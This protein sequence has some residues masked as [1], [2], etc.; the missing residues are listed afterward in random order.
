ML[1]ARLE[2][3]GSAYSSLSR[4]L[5]Q[6]YEELEQIAEEQESFT[7]RMKNLRI[8]ENNVR[9]KLNELSRKLQNADRMLHRGNIPGIPDE[10]E[11]RLEEADEQIYIVTQSL[12]EVPLNMNLVDSYLEN[13]EKAVNDVSGKVEELLENVMLI[14]WIIQ[15]GNR[16]RASNPEYMLVCWMRKN[17]SDN[18]AMPKH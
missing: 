18:F 17:H 6:I 10:M 11:A 7:N 14:E 1:S 2:E 3:Q 8:D 4:E 5:Q 13:A 16:Y 12:Q 9:T 15:Y